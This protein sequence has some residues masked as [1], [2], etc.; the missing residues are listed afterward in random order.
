MEHSCVTF[1]GRFYIP[2]VWRDDCLRALH[3][4]HP[5][6]VKRKLRAQ[7]NIYWL[8]INKEIDNH[9]IHCEWQALGKSQQ[10]DISYPN[11]Y[12]KQTLVKGRYWHI[13]SGQWVVCYCCWLLFKVSW[14]CQLPTTASKDKISVCI[15]YFRIWYSWGSHK[16]QWST[17]H[18]QRIPRIRSSVGIQTDHKQSIS[19]KGHGF[20]ERQA[21]TI[22]NLFDKCTKNG[23]DHYLALLQLSSTPLDS[24]TPS[25]EELL[26]NRQLRRTLQINITPPANSEAVRAASSQGRYALA[27]MLMTKS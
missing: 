14:I 17:A 3:Q 8:G 21:Q 9:V 4:G 1:Q 26:Q 24:R 22:K 25:S 18:S 5:D 12:S 20:I 7:T 11:G 27:M 15:L 2:S 13:P 19:S 16:W 23:S 10:K 6:I